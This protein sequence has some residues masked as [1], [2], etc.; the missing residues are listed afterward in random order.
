M[1][2]NVEVQGISKSFDGVETLKNVSFHVDS[3]E[4]VFLLGPS[5]CGKTTTLRIIAGLEQQDKG[6]VFIGGK[7][8]SNIPVHKRDVGFVFQNYALF[9]HMTVRQNIEFGLKMHNVP[10]KDYDSKVKNILSLVGLDGY[11]DRMPNQLS[12]GEKQRIS[13]CRTLVLNPKIL[14]LDEPLANLD[15]KLRKQMR[16]ELSKLQ[17]KIGIT[18]ICVTHDQEEAL[19]TADR[20]VLMNKGE[21]IQIGTPYEIYE[22]PVTRFVADFMG[23][24]NCYKGKIVKKEGKSITISSDYIPDIQTVVS[25]EE[26]YEVGDQVFFM[27]KKERIIMS[28]N[29]NKELF[30]TFVAKIQMAAYLGSHTE[31]ICTFKDKKGQ[32]MFR[33]PLD[34]STE[35][36]PVRGDE[37]RLEWQPSDVLLIEKI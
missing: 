37:V 21:I 28:T 29:N 11:E 10:R 1:M 22:K 27:I 4:F 32:I 19:S 16:V 30:N 9:P 34:S 14:L 17:K 20:I 33:L 25:R 31:Y 8:V 23:Q 24:V 3:G 7:E 18:T 15:A 12:G 13:I 5:G 2:S 6:K 35:K 26:E 36:L